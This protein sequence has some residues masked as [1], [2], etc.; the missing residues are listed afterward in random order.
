MDK[1]DYVIVY[2]C[3]KDINPE[4]EY[5]YLSYVTYNEAA[6]EAHLASDNVS[7]ENYRNEIYNALTAELGDGF[8]IIGFA[9]AYDK[10]MFDYSAFKVYRVLPEAPKDAIENEFID[11]PDSFIT[12]WCVREG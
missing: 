2:W 12:H 1:A 7:I 3:A 6:W 4:Y 9:D 10:I 8:A 11:D 5:E